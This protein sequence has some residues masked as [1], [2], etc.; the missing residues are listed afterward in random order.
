M[1]CITVVT[2]M[3]IV[4]IQQL[5]TDV[6]QFSSFSNV[7]LNDSNNMLACRPFSIPRN[8]F[9]RAISFFG[10]VFLPKVCF[11]IV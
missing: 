2:E 10:L 9:F 4:A 5:W 3:I 11:G 8:S 6:F 7:D 1:F